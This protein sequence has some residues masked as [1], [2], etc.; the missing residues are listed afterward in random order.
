MVSPTQNLSARS[1]KFVD[2]I[3]PPVNF[4]L[5]G[6][7]A[8]AHLWFLAQLRDTGMKFEVLT[9]PKC[10]KF[11]MVAIWQFK[12]LVWQNTIRIGKSSN[13]MGHGLN[14]CVDWL[15][16]GMLYHAISCYIMLYH[17]ISYSMD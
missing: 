11:G 16:E 5:L 10:G 9:H 3:E 8:Y 2:P 14:S 17:A 15:L 4:R 6:P 13:E 12:S 7:Y 1:R